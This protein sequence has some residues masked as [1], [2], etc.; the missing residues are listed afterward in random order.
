[1]TEVA[2]NLLVAD[3]FHAGFEDKAAL[4]KIFAR[5]DVDGSGHPAQT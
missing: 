3:A 5:I 1:M 4:K 2:S